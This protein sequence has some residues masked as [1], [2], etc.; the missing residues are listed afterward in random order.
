MA[1]ELLLHQAHSYPVDWWGLG[2][3][4]YEFMTGWPPFSDD[5]PEKV[6][7]NILNLKMDWPE[8]EEKLS[9]TAVN[10]IQSLLNLGK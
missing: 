4:L 5:T 7:E 2:V 9:D 8:E 3:C 10:A 6:F 1:P